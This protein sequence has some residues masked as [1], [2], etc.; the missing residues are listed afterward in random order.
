M[1]KTCI[2]Y[3]SRADENYFSGR[4]QNITMGN[5]EQVVH[6]IKKRV[7]ADSF[8]VQ[9]VTPYSKNY[10]QCIEE[11]M[12]DLKS[13]KEIALV[14]DID[15]TPYET[16]IIGYPI[17]WDTL[18]QALRVFLKHHDVA[19]KKIY[20]FS[21]HEGSGLGRSINDLKALC[22]DSEIKGTLAIKGSEAGSNSPK[23]EQLIK[24]WLK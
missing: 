16:I 23:V 14:E 24:E 9:Q 7:D 15:L 5:T 17:Y 8:K 4:I 6:M 18:P 3:Y 1:N 21:T 10:H 2:I 13:D 11:A 20:A 22:P 19:G 12:A